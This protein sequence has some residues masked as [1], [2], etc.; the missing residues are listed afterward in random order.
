MSSAMIRFAAPISYCRAAFWAAV[1]LA[2]AGCQENLG[3]HYGH[4]A[5]VLSDSV[6]G[7]SVFSEMCK[8]RDNRVRSWRHL[9]P[10]LHR[11][12]DVIIWFPDDFDPPSQEVRDW[13]DEWLDGG[14]NRTLI[15]VARD[16][17]A[18]PGYWERHSDA[19]VKEKVR[20]WRRHLVAARASYQGRRLKST[21]EI[22]AGWFRLD[23]SGAPRQVRSLAGRGDWLEGVDPSQVEIELT[24]RLLPAPGAEVWLNSDGDALVTQ[25][26]TEFGQRIVV[27]NGSFLLNLPLVNHEHRK[28]A[29]RLL[30]EVGTGRAVVFLE[31]GS[32]GPAIREKD[33]DEDGIGLQLFGRAPFNWLLLHLAILGAVYG[34]WRF[35]IFGVPR[36]RESADLTDFGRHI[37]AVG[38][39]MERSGDVQYAT[40]RISQ[41]R[42]ADSAKV[43]KT[44]PTTHAGPT[45]DGFPFQNP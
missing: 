34:F 31:S 12:A 38:Q 16:F 27:A 4:R 22:D 29:A 44:K 25:E 3:S 6:N 30:D 20:E 32:G 8:Q 41:Y 43:A 40:H 36:Q 21:V 28:L 5:G 9:S 15:Y 37:E 24:A 1:C 2:C 45:S 42:N 35:P 14:F 39:L 23:P 11:K 10:W 7:T 26:D 17:D 33:P 19:V 18:A 13:L